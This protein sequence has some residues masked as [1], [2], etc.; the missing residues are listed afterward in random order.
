M[1]KPNIPDWND[2]I[3]VRYEK[4]LR[5]RE[6]GIN[7]YRNGLT[8]ENLA[9]DI[10]KQY[11]S[12]SKEELDQKQPV[13]SV[14]GRIIAVRDFGKAGFVR[15]QDRS[16][17]IQVYVAKDK[18]GDSAYEL[19][20]NFTDIGDI[21]LVKGSVFRTKTNEL[22]ILATQYEFLTKALRPLPEKFHGI[23]DVELRYRHRSLDLIVNEYVRK[24]FRTRTKVI[25]LIRK[26]FDERDFLEADTPMMH[27]IAGG[28]AARPFKTHHN[29][30]DV[31][32]FMRI[33]TELHLKRLVVGGFDRVYEMN[34]IFRNEGI[35]IKHNPEFTSIEFYWAYATFEDLMKLTEDL[36]VML[37]KEVTGGMELEYQGQRIDFSSPWKRLSVFEAIQQYSGF[38]KSGGKITERKDVL[39]YLDKKQIHYEPKWPLGALQMAIFDAEVEDKLVQ[40]TF[41]THYPTDVSPLSRRNEKNPD[42]V[43]RFELYINGWE[44]ANAFSELNDPIDQ[45]ERFEDQAKAKAAGDEE[46]CDLDEDFL[47]ALEHGMPPTAGEGIGID[48]LVMLL[49]N[50]ASIRDVILFPQMRREHKQE[51]KVDEKEK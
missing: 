5:M 9:A 47:Y 45:R 30:L 16:G 27:S 20:K 31:E 6:K 1:K 14:A 22:S 38:S 21:V 44:L 39:S 43:D 25:S 8:P 3:Q 35:S 17:T 28:A 2:Q 42:V 46:A 40:P 48:R 12:L 41:I 18:L 26:F 36:F 50:S 51:H 13:A 34:R 33:A 15:I 32:L 4:M 24:T 19:Y 49:T 10:L 29:A 11:E 23:S 7:P 37:V